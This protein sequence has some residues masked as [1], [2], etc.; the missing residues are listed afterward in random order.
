[1]FRPVLPSPPGSR[2]GST[3]PTARGARSPSSP[4]A[5]GVLAASP[6]CCSFPAPSAT[7][8]RPRPEGCRWRSTAVH[9]LAGSVWL[10]GLIG[11]LV[12]WFATGSERACPS[13]GVVVP[14][15]SIVA[16]TAWS[17]CSPPARARRSS[18]CPP[19]TRCGR[20]VTAWRSSS[21]SGCSPRQS[22]LAA[23]NLLRTRPRLAAARRDPA[24]G[25]AAAR[26]LRRL[27]SGEALLVT[28]AVFAAAVLSSLAPPP[29]AFALR[30]RLSPASA[31]AGWPPASPVP[32]TACRC[33]SPPTRPRRPT[34]ALR[35]TRGGVPVRGAT[36]TLAFNHLEMQ[37]PQQEYEL[38]EVDPGLY[39][40][41][42]AGADHGRPLGPGLLDR[43][44]RARAVHRA[45]RRPGERMIGPRPT[46]LAAVAALLAD[47]G[48]D[49][50]ARGRY[51]ARQGR[52]AVADGA[53]L[54]TTGMA[55]RK[56][57][58]EQARARRLAEERARAAARASSGG[59]GWSSAAC[60]SRSR[61][62]PCS[63]PSPAA[64]AA[65]APGCRRAS[66]RPRRWPPSSSCWPASR[67]PGR[68]SG[69]ARRR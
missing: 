43:A 34:F 29:P 13:L 21:R 4:P 19:S 69:P 68:P 3:G 17:C 51:P 54:A 61:S 18:T 57:Q 41:Q 1:M 24:G 31:R 27:V 2:C 28:G 37:M 35:I 40:A 36:V 52:P 44:A 5:P 10:G 55:S 49:R 63:S 11:L 25:A 67:S 20:R 39:R 42:R 7:P 56:E 22:S 65:A 32:A 62:S 14:R 23:G 38:R 12:L 47:G 48:G 30:T 59:C 58:K 15:F 66:P 16:L 9:L 45:D 50:G 64:A 53:S 8:A 60:S 26:L 6:R 46:P 33:S